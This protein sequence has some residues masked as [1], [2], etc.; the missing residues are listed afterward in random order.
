MCMRYPGARAS[1]RDVSRLTVARS[2]FVATTHGEL[3]CDEVAHA[4]TKGISKVEMDSNFNE[5]PQRVA[6][7]ANPS[8]TS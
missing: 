4:A 6:P 3:L 1:I 5:S 2:P 7:D 8:A